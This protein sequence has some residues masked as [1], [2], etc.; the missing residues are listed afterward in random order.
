[1]TAN[2]RHTMALL[3]STWED[4][5]KGKADLQGYGNHELKMLKALSDGSKTL[6]ERCLEGRGVKPSLS[7]SGPVHEET[8]REAIR[9]ARRDRN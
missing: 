5:P 8:V 9:Q 6:R 4:L 2:V 3:L 1:M 7:I